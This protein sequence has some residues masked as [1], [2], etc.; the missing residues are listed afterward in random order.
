[1]KELQLPSGNFLMFREVEHEYRIGTDWESGKRCPG[2]HEVMERAEIIEPMN[3][4][5]RPW[6]ERGSRVHTATELD[7]LDQLSYSSDW[8]LSSE[9][10]YL[11]GYRQFKR[12]HP[13]FASPLT[14]EQLAGSEDY[15][16]ATIPDR[17]FDDFRLLQIKTGQP[18]KNHPVQLAIE[19]LLAFPSAGAFDRYA[20]YLAPDSS[21][22]LKLY[23]D[24]ESLDVATTI[25][26]ARYT[27]R[28]FMTT[29]RKP[30]KAI[31]TVE[32][33]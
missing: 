27:V 11:I 16:C 21:Y 28:K 25:M 31:Q 5:M 19:G 23:D 1:V 29:R 13:E 10:G 18:A 30:V 4:A 32:T 2:S 9:L 24:Q 6:V 33:K 17:T 26:R 12:D 20:L 14:V 15:W 22:A 8:V 3:E 7:D